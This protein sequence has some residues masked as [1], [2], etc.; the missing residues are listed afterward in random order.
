MTDE[1]KDKIKKESKNVIIKYHCFYRVFNSLSKNKQ[2]WILDSMSIGK[3]VIPY[4]MI[5]SFDSLNITRIDDDFFK[6]ED[7][8]SSLKN[9]IISK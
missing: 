5:N 4:E 2:E 8:H 7:F 3:G 6:I 1:E 9:S